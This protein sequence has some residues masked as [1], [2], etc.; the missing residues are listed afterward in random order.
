MFK[1]KK[2]LIALAI[3]GGAIGMTAAPA[4]A[5]HCNVNDQPDLTAA[6]NT[7]IAIVCGNPK[8]PRCL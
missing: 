7:V 6:C 5:M 8:L 4:Q 1:F 3:A 2:S